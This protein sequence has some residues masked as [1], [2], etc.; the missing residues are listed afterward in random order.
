MAGAVM[1]AVKVARVAG[2][3]AEVSSPYALD[4]Q[5]FSGAGVLE[6]DGMLTSAT[7]MLIDRP[8]GVSPSAKVR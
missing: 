2:S 6:C 1:V 7:A 5:S 4:C 3:T 8:D